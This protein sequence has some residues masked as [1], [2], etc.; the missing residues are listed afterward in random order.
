[1]SEKKPDEG[2]GGMKD[3]LRDEFDEAAGKKRK[4]KGKDDGG[5]GSGSMKENV[6]DEFREAA[7]ADE[8][9]DD[10]SG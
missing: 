9:K 2:S 10:D 6:Q 8:S 3:N 1:M 5:D 4:G 7:G